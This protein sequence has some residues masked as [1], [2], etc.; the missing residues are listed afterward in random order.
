[1]NRAGLPPPASFILYHVLSRLS[2]E[3][4]RM[5]LREDVIFIGEKKVTPQ[6]KY[7]KANTRFI[8][9]KLNKKTDK[10]ILD[11]IEGLPMQTELK[12]LIRIG[13]AAESRK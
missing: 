11:A 13:I 5:Y 8:G 2:R 9:L 4:L 10:D 1:M 12:R 6:E 7:D 3:T